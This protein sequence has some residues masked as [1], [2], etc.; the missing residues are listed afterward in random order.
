MGDSETPSVG[1]TTDL[2]D[3]LQALGEALPE[4]HRPVPHQVPNIVSGLIYWLETGSLDAP[5]Y[6][7]DQPQPV[8]NLDAEN[9]ELRAQIAALEANQ[10]PAPPVTAAVPVPDST[11]AKSP[12]A[13]TPTDPVPG[14]GQGQGQNPPASE[15]PVPDGGQGQ[16]Q[17]PTASEVP[18]T[19]AS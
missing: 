9:A 4:S 16:G 15:V 11:L 13:T 10:K 1:T 17:N 6:E 19:P 2:T 14:G 8:T 7:T 5:V 3:R 12:A 18:S